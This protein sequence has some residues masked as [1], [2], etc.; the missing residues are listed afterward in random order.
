M[1][2]RVLASRLDNRLY[3]IISIQRV[4]RIEKDH[5]VARRLSQSLV[6]RIVKS[7]VGL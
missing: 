6:H 1:V 2:C 7:T 4:A 5:I 3:R